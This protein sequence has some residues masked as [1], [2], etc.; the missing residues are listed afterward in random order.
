MKPL[1]LKDELSRLLNNLEMNS[2]SVNKGHLKRIISCNGVL[3]CWYADCV[4]ASK[5]STCQCIHQRSH[6]NIIGIEISVCTHFLF[7]H[8]ILK[9][10]DN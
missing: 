10:Q 8:H 3:Q 7:M 9:Q 6:A 4:S 1:S 2:A 5:S